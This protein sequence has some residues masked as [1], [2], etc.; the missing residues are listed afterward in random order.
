MLPRA[1]PPA[2]AAVS[3]AASAAASP[4]AAS[5]MAASFLL[6]LPAVREWG[7]GGLR[8]IRVGGGQSRWPLHSEASG[9]LPADMQAAGAGWGGGRGRARVCYAPLRPC[10]RGPGLPSP[11][12]PSVEVL[13]ERVDALG[14]SPPAATRVVLIQPGGSG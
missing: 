1:R 11:P 13:T 10:P 7:C 12:P 8:E 2:T 14:L 9:R 3:A 5:T 6:C 4:A